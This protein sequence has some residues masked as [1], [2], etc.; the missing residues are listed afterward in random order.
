MILC[1][2]SLHAAAFSCGADQILSHSS[3]TETQACTTSGYCRMTDFNIETGV[4]EEFYGFHPHCPG[5]Q[6][7]LIEEWFCRK[8]DETQS[9][10]WDNDV[11]V[12]GLC[13]PS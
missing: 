10:Y 3:R 6:D 2:L 5:Q 11:S 9:T 4:V 1:L 7:R 12:W 8:N 13:R